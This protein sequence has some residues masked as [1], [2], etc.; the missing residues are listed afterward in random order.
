MKSKDGFVKENEENI[1]DTETKWSDD[2]PK[3]GCEKVTW[4]LNIHF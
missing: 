1:A 3:V 2:L 4:Q